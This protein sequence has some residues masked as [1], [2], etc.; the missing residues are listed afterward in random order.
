MNQ[1]LEIETRTQSKARFS[2][3]TGEFKGVFLAGALAAIAILFQRILNLENLSPLIVA[4][5]LGTLVRNTIGI[6]PVFQ[7]GIRFC[8]KR[9]LRLAI[10][11][12][13]LRLSLTEIRAL[14]GEGL[15]IIGITLMSTFFFT[16]WLGKRLGINAKLTQLIAAGTSICGASAVVA[17][18]SVVEGTEEDTA[19]AVAMVTAFGSLAMLLY[20]ILPSLLNLTPEA[21]GI[22][23]GA[24]IHEV[25][26]V[27]ASAFQYGSVSG[28]L[29][30]ISKLS[31]ILFLA[32]MMLLLNFISVQPYTAHQKLSFNQLPIPWFVLLFLLLVVFNSF[33]LI[34][35]P[36]KASLLQFNAF[37][38]TV[39]LAAMGLETNLHRI[40]QVGITPVYLAGASWL[41]LAAIS[42]GLIQLFY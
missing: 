39:S 34:P 1:P 12:L 31:R 10:I 32:P 25:A 15:A 26:Q 6:S 14:G 17:A 36:V 13:G 29:A 35:I 42:L 8:L 41:F 23:C 38:L 4:I 20:P 3:G 37:L 19:Y 27:I 18:S 21:F 22:W 7:P 30:T 16:C 2:L 9:I 24:S 11:L 40:Q 33:Q 5:L 28:E